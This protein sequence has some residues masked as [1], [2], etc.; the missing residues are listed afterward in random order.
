VAGVEQQ[1]AVCGVRLVRWTSHAWPAPAFDP[2][3]RS[4]KRARGEKRPALPAP[5]LPAL[6]DDVEPGRL[7][8]AEP[9]ARLLAASATA[10][11][12]PRVE[13]LAEAAAAAADASRTAGVLRRLLD[14]GRSTAELLDVMLRWGQGAALQIYVFP[15]L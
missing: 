11:H 12:A 9:L 10:A 4:W 3:Y 15:M 13:A 8:D 6:P 7:P 1:L 14:G 2:N 5:A